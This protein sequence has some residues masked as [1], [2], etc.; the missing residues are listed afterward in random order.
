MHSASEAALIDCLH[1]G[2]QTVRRS[3]I[4]TVF[5]SPIHENPLVY[6][7]DLIVVWSLRNQNYILLEPEI[8]YL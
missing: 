7:L 5:V 4:I 2:Q 1:S 3:S 8:F 6:V